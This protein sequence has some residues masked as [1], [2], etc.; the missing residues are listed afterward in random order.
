MTMTRGLRVL[1]AI[2]VGVAV[3][4][5]IPMWSLGAWQGALDQAP[6]DH[7]RESIGWL[8]G[9]TSAFWFP[10]VCLVGGI[11]GLCCTAVLWP[12]RRKPRAEDRHY[13]GS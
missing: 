8:L 12:W 10:A 11:L 2:L 9:L 7:D 4:V 1:L 3:G 13:H 5:A 6:T